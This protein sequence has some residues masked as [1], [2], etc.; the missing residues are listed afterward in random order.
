MD[1]LQSIRTFVWIAD[2]GSYSRA[3]E[4]LNISKS[5]ATRL[6][7]SLEK[8]LNTRLMDRNTRSLSLTE[9]GEAYLERVRPILRDLERAE[10]LLAA[11]TTRPKGALR[12]AAPVTFGLHDLSPLLGA[13][14]KRYPDVALD[15][16]LLDRPIN[17]IDER[18]DVGVLMSGQIVG[19]N[20]VRQPL[21]TTRMT[22]CAA[23][24]YLRKHGEP[25]HPADLAEHAGLLLSCEHGGEQYEFSGPGGAVQAFLTTAARAN[26]LIMLRELAVLG[27]GVAILPGHMIADDLAHGRLVRLLNDYRL[28]PIEMQ[29]AYPRLNHLPATV[30]TFVDHCIACMGAAREDA[31]EIREREANR[32]DLD[33]RPLAVERMPSQAAAW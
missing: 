11:Q 24:A 21:T 16:R 17:L 12:I 13:Y 2:L 19:D 7:I 5:V 26:S 22:P 1:Y 25:T 31:P 23:P 4:T 9:Q 6:V 27:M 20:L 15:V 18:F 14:S 33:T 8:H 10:Q 32:E 28:A 3:A 29:L 30:R